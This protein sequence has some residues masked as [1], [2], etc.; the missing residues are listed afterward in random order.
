MQYELNEHVIKNLEIAKDKKECI[1]L[2]YNK[3]KNT[4]KVYYNTELLPAAE[5]ESILPNELGTE[6][7]DD[8]II[9]IHP[10]T[11]MTEETYAFEEKLE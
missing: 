2:L 5:A 1:T 8:N 3:H 6:V 9:I 4:K 11:D 7:A 10:L